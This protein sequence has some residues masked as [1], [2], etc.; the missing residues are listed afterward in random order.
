MWPHF[1]SLAQVYHLES[2]PFAY[3]LYILWV[4]FPYQPGFILCIASDCTFWYV[5]G[6][7]K[8]GRDADADQ[9]NAKVQDHS[10]P[11][12]GGHSG[13]LWTEGLYLGP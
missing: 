3:K 8:P 13:T 1:Y 4:T 10:A 11:D 6:I 2:F 9:G 5:Q 7:H 12:V